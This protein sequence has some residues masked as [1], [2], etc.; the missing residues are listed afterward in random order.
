MTHGWMREE[1][2]TINTGDSLEPS[3]AVNFV[4]VE[5]VLLGRRPRE[6]PRGQAIQSQRYGGGQHCAKVATILRQRR[7][8]DEDRQHTSRRHKGTITVCTTQYQLGL[9][10]KLS[11]YLDASKNDQL[12]DLGSIGHKR[13]TVRLPLQPC[14]HAGC[15]GHGMYF[16]TSDAPRS[17]SWCAKLE[18]E[19]H[20]LIHLPH[21]PVENTVACDVGR[22]RNLRSQHRPL[23]GSATGT[24]T[25]DLHGTTEGPTASSKKC[26]C[27]P[28]WL[29]P[30]DRKNNRWGREG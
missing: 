24:T 29:E 27:Q 12:R 14:R 18:H 16:S 21:T 10:G 13:C 15:R 1:M 3:E 28:R 6:P 20:V 19:R 26:G 2:K 30:K 11:A 7:G 9:S 4:G 8:E 22:P 5:L 25:G 17:S 23:H